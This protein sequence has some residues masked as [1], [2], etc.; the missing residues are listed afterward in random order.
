M[1][2]VLPDLP[3]L[4]VT[5]GRE[6][7]RVDE[8]TDLSDSWELRRLGAQQTIGSHYGQDAFSSWSWFAVHDMKKR[9]PTMPDV[10]AYAFAE[11]FNFANNDC[12]LLLARAFRLGEI[13]AEMRRLGWFILTGWEMGE[14]NY[15]D[16]ECD[17]GDVFASATIWK[18]KQVGG[19]QFEKVEM[20]GF[21]YDRV[22]DAA[23]AAYK[24]VLKVSNA[25]EA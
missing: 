15:V 9:G 14:G 6:G 23:A 2:E 12:T 22:I 5:K 19:L 20:V 8:Y 7:D 25:D 24:H 1:R 4:K 21:S 3:E 11:P 13:V 18:M 10:G 16:G 17:G